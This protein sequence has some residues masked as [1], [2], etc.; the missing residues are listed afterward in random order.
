MILSPAKNQSHQQLVQVIPEKS[1]MK[2]NSYFR[3]EIIA[4]GERL[5][6][7]Y[8]L[9]D[10]EHSNSP[11][12]L[13]ELD[14]NSLA[15]KSPIY[16]AYNIPSS[17]DFRLASD[18]NSL[19]YAFQSLSNKDWAD[20]DSIFLN[21]ARYDISKAPPVLTGSNLNITKGCPFDNRNL[22]EYPENPELVDDPTPIY[23]QGKYVVL[24]RAWKGTVQHIRT[25][26][27][28]LTLLKDFTI[29]LS[30]VLGR[31]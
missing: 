11:Y 9:A 3:P 5:F 27:S 16:Y 12:N 24:T 31:N 30:S 25:F 2:D 13:V 15:I 23:Y 21:I 19:W 20:C 26:D 4:V 10:K 1:V 6:L 28:S 17:I 14:K 22:K 29:D 7:M 8:I 18:G